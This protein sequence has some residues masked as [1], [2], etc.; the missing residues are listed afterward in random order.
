MN[1]PSANVVRVDSGN[2]HELLDQ[3][4]FEHFDDIQIE[5]HSTKTA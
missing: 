4:H 2:W 1:T 3:L 5:Q